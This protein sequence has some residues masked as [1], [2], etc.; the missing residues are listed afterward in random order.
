M[1]AAAVVDAAGRGLV[2][3]AALGLIGVGVSRLVSVPVPWWLV[4]AAPLALGAVG[5]AIAGMAR[6]GSLLRAASAVDA[7]LRLKDRLGTATALDGIGSGTNLF[8][9]LAVADADE[10]SS[11]IDPRRAVPIRFGRTWTLWPVLAISAAAIGMF[12]P[13]TDL[14]ASLRSR[15]PKEVAKANVER[16]LTE[17]AQATPPREPAAMN[18][19]APPPPKSDAAKVLDEIRKELE[20]GKSTPDK[21]AERGARE[22]DRI[23]AE[24]ENKADTIERQRDQVSETLR[25]MKRPTE[26]DGALSK[27]VRSGDMAA[28]AD[29]AKDLLN[30]S[31]E[32]D[33]QAGREKAAK[34]LEQLAKDLRAAAKARED[35]KAAAHERK[36]PPSEPSDQKPAENPATKPNAERAPENKSADNP[37][38][39]DAA[40][41]LARSIEHAAE[42]IK[43][44][45]QSHA[46]SPPTRPE[47]ASPEAEKTDSRKTP[48]EKHETTPQ[49]TSN[50][51]ES[52]PRNAPPPSDQNYREQS[53]N[54]APQDAKQP[55]RPPQSS[56][57]SQDQGKKQESQSREQSDKPP[58][59]KPSAQQQNHQQQPNQP[60]DGS[61]ERDKGDQ[62]AKPSPSERPGESSSANQPGQ[63]RQDAAAKPQPKS[64]GDQPTGGGK[65]EQSPKKDG[66]QTGARDVNKREE[67]TGA[68]EERGPKKDGGA[69]GDQHSQ[70]QSAQSEKQPSDGS[71]SD[72]RTD[73]GDK[74]STKE[75][76]SGQTPK[77]TSEPSEQ[78]KA[79]KSGAREQPDS[80]NSGERPNGSPPKPD[81]ASAGEKPDAAKPN[82]K[83]TAV[84]DNKRTNSK[85]AQ[86][87]PDEKRPEGD[88]GAPASD[89]QHEGEPQP[90]PS[91]TNDQPQLPTTPPSKEAIRRLAEHFK[92]LADAP[93]DAAAQ[94][95]QAQDMRK[96]AEELLKSATPEQREQLK[97]WGQELAKEMQKQ[98]APQDTQQTS[99][100]GSHQPSSPISHSSDHGTP[101]GGGKGIDPAR[102]RTPGDPAT[103]TE[104]VD[105]RPPTSAERAEK[106]RER[107]IAEW[108]ADRKPDAPAS[109]SSADPISSEGESAAQAAAR[110]GERAVETQAVPG[111][112]DK[113]LLKYFQRLPERAKSAAPAPSTS[114][115]KQALPAQDAGGDKR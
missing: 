98:G 54:S 86:Q 90:S 84:A 41:D 89:K 40:E 12:A 107:V 27:A 83:P 103:R 55:P 6:R 23:A 20:T 95:Q 56:T 58:A 112:F 70:P 80:G 104:T 87:S 31:P 92:K 73:E 24:R 96:K 16:K 93:K 66:S 38:E 5:G 28:A 110:D 18:P 26:E 97:R 32:A 60:K 37:H 15:P 34:E 13:S 46:Q 109:A 63:P 75:S 94:R 11:R 57:A 65:A 101:D 111:R 49:T 29:A 91:P 61:S 82:G 108:Y 72:G 50:T 39:P 4:L 88:Q 17:L 10:A 9:Q 76:N 22:L 100:E 1:T 3:G 43:R 69:A 7:A 59:E 47:P 19:A 113:L 85:G 36:E 78:G 79:E 45:P 105:A 14:F 114:A 2:W 81:A 42:A 67:Q 51:S 48:S 68:Q 25:D 44:E 74:K 77:Q 62:G 115:T 99:G 52:Q 21:A 64:S 35:A 102:P 33:S 30:A 71:H 8:A 106:R 53:P